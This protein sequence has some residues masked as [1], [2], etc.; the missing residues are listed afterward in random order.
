LHSIGRLSEAAELASSFNPPRT[1]LAAVRRAWP[2]GVVV[3]ADNDCKVQRVYGGE[4]SL[5]ANGNGNYGDGGDR[6][7]TAAQVD[8]NN[9]ATP[10]EAGEPGEVV[11]LGWV[12]PNGS[13][14]GRNFA[15]D[16]TNN[17][18]GCVELSRSSSYASAG[19]IGR[20]E[21]WGFALDAIGWTYFPGN[22]RGVVSLTRAQLRD[23]YTCAPDNPTRTIIKYWGEL[24]GRAE[25]IG[26]GHEIKAYRVQPGSGT[27]E[28]VASVLIGVGN[29]NGIGQNCSGVVFPVVQEHDCTAVSDAD[30]PDAI[31]F[32]G[33]S[34]WRIQARAL[35]PDKRNG[36]RFGAFSVTANDTPL[37]PT[38]STIRETTGR[39]AG[40]RIVYTMVNVGNVA[41]TPPIYTPGYQDAIDFA[42]VRPAGGIDRNSN[43]NFNDP[44]DV[45]SPG[46][47]A[48]PGF[49]CAAGP[50]QKIIRTYG[51][52]PFKI[53]VT[54]PLNPAYGQSFCR[55]NYQLGS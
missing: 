17:P 49:V 37:R 34:R 45:A 35:E 20:L 16:Y 55:R 47:Q 31:C 13:G 7:F 38:A 3:P 8:A 39:Y 46:A 54:D 23:I 41:A 21:A 32:Y 40:T 15:L 9:N 50:A 44:G 43:G 1:W 18:V 14:S 6:R 52:V 4:G 28:D 22:T 19:Q 27:S 10:G 53:G 25:E 29:N 24:N 26:P 48:Q 30:K 2:A 5:D 42:G 51:M 12:A 11:Q 33:Y 36:A